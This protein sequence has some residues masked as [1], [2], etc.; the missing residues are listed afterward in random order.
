M[1]CELAARPVVVD[2]A[3]F[4]EPVHEETHP[5]AGCAD[6]F[7]KRLL[8]DLGDYNVGNAFLAKMSEQEQDPGQSLFAGIEELVN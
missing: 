7:C 4:P 3:Q 5:R 1:N 2:E 8:A 6:H